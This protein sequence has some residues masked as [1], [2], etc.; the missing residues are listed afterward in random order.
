MLTELITLFSNKISQVIT[1]LVT[2]G[3]NNFG[4]IGNGLL[5]GVFNYTSSLTN[6]I[7]QLISKLPQNN[8]PSNSN[9]NVV[10]IDTSNRLWSW[11]ANGDGQLGNG[12]SQNTSSPVQIGA[13]TT[14]SQVTNSAFNQ[15]ALKSDNTIW[16]WGR[17][18]TYGQ[19]GDGTVASK[20]SP[21]QWGVFTPQSYQKFSNPVSIAA[22]TTNGFQTPP[23]LNIYT[24]NFAAVD[25]GGRLW[26][27]GQNSNGVLGLGDTIARSSACQVGSLTTWSKVSMTGQATVA[28]KTDGTMWSWGLSGYNGFTSSL[29]NNYSSPVQIG[30]FTNW[31]QIVCGGLSLALRSTGDLYV[32]GENSSPAINTGGA[33]G[34]SID[35]GIATTDKSIAVGIPN[36]TDSSGV[37]T[38]TNY[39]LAIPSGG[40]SL[41]GYGSNTV[42]QLG[43]NSVTGTS[44]WSTL[45]SSPMNGSTFSKIVCGVAHTLALMADGTLWA[46][47]SN[48]FGQLGD[49]T[50]INRSSPVQIAGT[51]TDIAAGNFSS[52]AVKSGSLYAWGINT[53]YQLGQPGNL[54][55]K[56]SPVLI[57][58]AGNPSLIAAGI[59]YSGWVTNNVLYEV[60]TGTSGVLGQNNTTNTTGT[61]VQVSVQPSVL[62]TWSQV[63]GGEQTF[64]ATNTSGA[65]YGSG[66]LYIFGLGS[67]SSGVSSP[68]QVDSGTA[69][70]TTAGTI[71]AKVQTGSNANAYAIRSTSNT[72]VSWGDN[73]YGQLGNGVTGSLAFSPIIVGSG[74]SQVSS[75]Y[76]SFYGFGFVVA[77]KTNGTLWAWGPNSSGQLGD[78]T[79]ASR[80]SPVQIGSGTN[81]TKVAAGDRFWVALKSDGT[82]WGCGYNFQAAFGATTVNS[83]YSSPVQIGSATNWSSISTLSQNTFATNTSNALYGVGDLTSGQQGNNALNITVALNYSS[84]VLISSS[85]WNKLSS[86]L[87]YNLAIKNDFTLW[88]WGAN[89]TGQLGD[90]TSASKSSPVQIGALAVWKDVA[91]GWDP[92]GNN[93]FLLPS[94]GPEYYGYS[95]AIDTSNKLYSWGCNYEGQLGS[96]TATPSGS[97]SILNSPV[98][99][100]SLTNWNKVYA[101]STGA[102]Y[103]IKTDNTMWSWGYNGVGELGLGNIVARSSPVQIGSGTSW[104]Q[105]AT[106]PNS[107]AA[108]RT[109]GDLFAWGDNSQGQLGDGTA[110]NKS[111]PVQIGSDVN[112]AKVFGG[113]YNFFAV[114]TDGTLWAWGY[115]ANGQLGDGTT[116]SKS[117]PVQIGT[118]FIYVLPYGANTMVA[119]KSDG[120]L[121]GWGSAPSPQIG[122]WTTSY[123]SPVQ[124]NLG[125][126]VNTRVPSIRNAYIG[127][128]DLA[129][130][131]TS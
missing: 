28:I 49:I 114:K 66:D 56:S 71:G 9:Y 118:G 32:F 79:T 50:V 22:G 104:F 80:S 113:N 4:Q 5:G 30:S 119:V 58:Q 29:A 95:L 20:S 68:V 131:K 39:A 44:T 45:I 87:Y 46:W 82:I 63:A 110:V 31:S 12:N 55:N 1:G 72:L 15:A 14:W 34:T 98:Q 74:Y 48:G 109:N 60:G 27:W 35:T 2:L 117:S 33:I 81:W 106:C 47:G 59:A 57:G 85:S 23:G 86:G 77:I 53:S 83:S 105:L 90:S 88:G 121:W 97:S 107:V 128:G 67:F 17:N 73:T 26:T 62:Q 40:G 122:S 64:L 76:D 65:L 52:F 69:Y 94:S 99:V 10:A 124:L 36:Y 37:I 102:S 42:G 125:N 93:G 116:V 54:Q 129:L 6:F 92:Y 89:L 3:Y 24:Y 130:I 51:W 91:T 41:R 101:N 18:S 108:I 21:V 126:Y 127:F 25:S 8:S 112:W 103:A 61:Q 7:S 16:V 43:N 115:N 38:K 78:G 100:G 70:L 13:L 96:G 11:G 75:G 111:S 84:P 123:S 19:L 120:T